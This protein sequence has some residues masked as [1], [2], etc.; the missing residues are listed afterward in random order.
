MERR[1]AALNA[2]SVDFSPWGRIR[3]PCTA[4]GG[5]PIEDATGLWAQAKAANTEFRQRFPQGTARDTEA[6]GGRKFGQR[7]RYQR[8]R[9]FA[10]G[11]GRRDFCRPLDAEEVRVECDLRGPRLA[12]KFDV[13]SQLGTA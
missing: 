3:Q 5:E 11:S 2:S 8:C 4:T 6:R 10:Q 1:S 7:L 13:H 9:T 12:P